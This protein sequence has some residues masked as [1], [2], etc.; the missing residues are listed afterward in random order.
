RDRTKRAVVIA[1]NRLAVDDA[2]PRGQ[3]DQ[4]LDD[5][6][7][8]RQTG[9]IPRPCAG[10]SHRAPFSCAVGADRQECAQRRA[11]VRAQG[12]RLLLRSHAGL[13]KMTTRSRGSLFIFRSP[14]AVA[15]PG[16]TS[17]EGTA[18]EEQQVGWIAA[19]IIGGIAGWLAEKFMK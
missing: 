4:C 1:G 16:A 15:P 3:A 12:F 14:P 8:D 11:A 19:T 7:A 18:M 17:Q 9:P 10:K 6:R 2:G 13:L 5:Q